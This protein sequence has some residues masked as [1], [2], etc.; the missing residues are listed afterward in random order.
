MAEQFKF[1]ERITANVRWFGIAQVFQYLL[2]FLVWAFLARLLPADDF[3]SLGIALAFTNL[4]SVLGELGMSAAIIQKK[5]VQT[6]DLTTFFWINILI[7]LTFLFLSVLGAPAVAR[8]FHSDSVRILLIMLAGKF[9]IDSF[10]GVHEVFLQKNLS[11]KSLSIIEVSSSILFG[12]AAIAMAFGG[13]GII[14]LAW[15]YI[16]KSVWKVV[17]LWRVCPFRPRWEF[18]RESF[19]ELFV[20][21]RN[22]IGYKIMSYLSSNIEILLIGWFLGATALGYYSLALNLVNFPRQKLS[23]IVSQ[24]AF[25]AFSKLQDYKDD[26]RGAYQKLIR[27]AAVINF[28]LLAGLMLTSPQLVRAAFSTRWSPIIIPLQI[29]CVYGASFSL[30]TFVGII[31]NSTGHPEYAFRL[32]LIHFI[33]TIVATVIGCRFG[34]MGVAL[35]L[36]FF[37]VFMNICGNLFV[38]KNIGLSFGAYLKCL[39][40]AVQSLGVMMAILIILIQVDRVWL[41]MPDILFLFSAVLIAVPVYALALYLFSKETFAEIKRIAT[42]LLGAQRN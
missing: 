37:A 18:D 34:L 38:K 21:G 28:P 6:K 8:F 16:A 39:L 27:Y 25:P 36:S 12:V 17:L 20:F 22:I 1:R 5:D 15:G 24:V 4:I 29:L 2:Q 14:S 7:C 32:S 31:F 3:G 26:V 35:G 11:F 13:W 30:T 42:S 19:R 41:K 23:L 9:L 33:G 10:A 40:P